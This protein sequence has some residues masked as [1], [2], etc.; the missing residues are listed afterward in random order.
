[1]I[2]AHNVMPEWKHT[3]LKFVAN[4]IGIKC[5]WVLVVQADEDENVLP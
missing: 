5:N 4:M 3:V 2:L 1:M